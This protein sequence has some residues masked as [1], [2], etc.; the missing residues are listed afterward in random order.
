MHPKLIFTLV[1]ILSIGLVHSFPYAPR[2]SRFIGSS[3]H[4]HLDTASEFSSSVQQT[5]QKDVNVVRKTGIVQPYFNNFIGHLGSPHAFVSHH[6][7]SGVGVISTG[8]IAVHPRRIPVVERPLV[9]TVGLPE[10]EESIHIYKEETE[11]LSKTPL[12]SRGGFGGSGVGVVQSDNT[13]KIFRRSHVSKPVV[14][15]GII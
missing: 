7:P 1:A 6:S 3:G 9:G 4:H 12:V 8:P 15:G 10:E 5:Y 2:G 11:S 14:T 13:E